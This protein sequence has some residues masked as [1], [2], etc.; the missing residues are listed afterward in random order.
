MVAATEPMQRVRQLPTRVFHL[1]M[2]F[3]DPAPL[4]SPIS[5]PSAQGCHSAYRTHGISAARL[6]SLKPPTIYSESLG[7]SNSLRLTSDVRLLSQFSAFP[8]CAA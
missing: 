8:F 2:R 7:A 5:S 6:C 1:Y 4:R 3:S